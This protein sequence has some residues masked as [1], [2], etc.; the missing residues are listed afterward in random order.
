MLYFK[1]SVDSVLHCYE[2]SC[3]I[4]ISIIIYVNI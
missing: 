1:V 2:S 3:T 4:I